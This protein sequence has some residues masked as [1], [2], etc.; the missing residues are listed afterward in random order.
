MLEEHGEIG[1][2]FQCAGLVNPPSMR[3]VNLQQTILQNIDAK[4]T[5]QTAR[6]YLLELKGK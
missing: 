1:R 3:A 6:W 4:F 5:P 2:P